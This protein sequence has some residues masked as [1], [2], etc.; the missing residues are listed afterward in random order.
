MNAPK[1]NEHPTVPDD[2]QTRVSPH[3]PMQRDAAPIFLHVQ[4]RGNASSA[5]M[6]PVDSRLPLPVSQVP[7]AFPRRFPSFGQAHMLQPFLGP[8][9]RVRI[10]PVMWMSIEVAKQ[11]VGG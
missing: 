10:H 1:R 5:E 4:S 2:G 6:C 8:R 3:G 9:D 11:E 7:P